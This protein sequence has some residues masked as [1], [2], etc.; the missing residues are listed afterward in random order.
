MKAVQLHAYGDVDQ[1]RYEDVPT[2]QPAGDEVLVRVIATS[3]NPVDWKIRSGKLKDRMPLQFPYILGRDVSGEVVEVGADVKDFES[4]QKVMGFVNGSYAEYLTAKATALTLLPDG[5][6]QIKAGALPLVTLTGAQLIEKGVQPRAGET[7][8][9]TGAV[10]NVGRTAVHVAKQHGAKVI[11]GVRAEQKEAAA[12]LGAHRVI[13]LDDEQAIA[14]LE[15]LDAIADTVNGDTIARLIPK[16]KQSGRIG[17]VVGK[18]AAADKAGIPVTAVQA[19][20][21]AARLHQ[22]ARDFQ[23]GDLKIPINRTFKLADIREAQKFAE[24]G[25]NGKVI[26]IP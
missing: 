26:L 1:L 4:G 22:L 19:Q 10:G 13:A 24:E 23:A 8:L 12:A 6:D 7:V 11:A 3:I 20:P 14:A 21:D 2:P 9:V 25:A 18:P 17:S 16:L 5:L 15:P